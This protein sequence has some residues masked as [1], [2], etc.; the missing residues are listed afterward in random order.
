MCFDSFRKNVYGYCFF[1]FNV[2]EVKNIGVLLVG[3]IEF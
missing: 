3:I 2:G 1:F